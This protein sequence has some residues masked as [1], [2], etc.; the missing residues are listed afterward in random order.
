MGPPGRSDHGCGNVESDNLIGSRCESGVNPIA[1]CFI[2]QIRF[3]DPAKPLAW[4][5]V[6]DEPDV[7]GIAVATP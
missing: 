3:Q 4:E 5:P 2:E 1:D 7:D 6:I